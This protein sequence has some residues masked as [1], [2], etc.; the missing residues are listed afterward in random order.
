MWGCACVIERKAQVRG[1]LLYNPSNCR[2]ASLSKLHSISFW[3]EMNLWMVIIYGHGFI[4]AFD[5]IDHN[6]LL[7]VLW[8][9]E[10]S[11]MGMDS[12]GRCKKLSTCFFWSVLSIRN[13]GEIQPAHSELSFLIYRWYSVTPLPSWSNRSC[14]NNPNTNWSATVRHTT[15]VLHG[16]VISQITVLALL[17]LFFERYE[18]RSGGAVKGA[19][20]W[21]FFGKSS[22]MGQ[23]FLWHKDDPH[24]SEI[25]QN[26]VFP[27]HH[28]RPLG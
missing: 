6:I 8:G 26:I 19:L 15:I 3:D 22:S 10:V 9:F 17:V 27:H 13:H 12:N 14:G 28:P 20:W 21:R 11:E 16:L 2:E 4:Q 5:H 25:R 7:N 18:E 24:C 23:P 1:V